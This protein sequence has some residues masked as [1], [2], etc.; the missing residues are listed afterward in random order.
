MGENI[1][2]PNDVKLILKTLDKYNYESFVVGGAIRNLLLNIPVK[3]W[4][5]TTNATPTQIK[6]CFNN[7][8]I[9]HR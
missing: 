8:K 1:K 7:Y 3:D 2:I 6:E 4:D 5:I 9:L